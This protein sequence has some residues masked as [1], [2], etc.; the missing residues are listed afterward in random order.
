MQISRTVRAVTCAAEGSAASDGCGSDSIFMARQFWP[1]GSGVGRLIR[2]SGDEPH[3]IIGIARDHKV[4]SVGEAPR[5]YLHVPAGRSTSVSLIVRTTTPA[6]LALPT[7]RTALWG[8]EPN[9]VFTEDAPAQEVADA[10]VAPTRIG[11]VV[12]MAFGGL[13]LVLAALGVYGV[14]AYSVSRR[15]HEIGIRVALG[16]GP[17]R[18]LRLVVGR[19]LIL[20]VTGLGLGLAGAAAVTRVLTG[21]LFEVKATDPVVFAVTALLLFAVALAA[22]L[23]PARKATQVDPLTALRHE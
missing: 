10:T 21:L 17:G 1:D 14:V 20:I 16:S 6:A 12:L 2:V 15:T 7:L 8:L 9:I 4:R 5:P 22:C 11:A 18:I 13:A 19:G 3:Q 23:V